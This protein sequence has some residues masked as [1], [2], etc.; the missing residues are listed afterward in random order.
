[1]SVSIPINTADGRPTDFA[2]F[3]IPHIYI[4]FFADYKYTDYIKNFVAEFGI[5]IKGTKFTA[6]NINYLLICTLISA[7]TVAN[8]HGEFR[9]RFAS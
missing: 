6:D 2:T 4:L 9:I 3:G 8:S 5:K 7:L 1:M